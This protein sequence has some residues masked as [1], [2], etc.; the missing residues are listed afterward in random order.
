MSRKKTNAK[1]SAPK[2]GAKKT[3]KAGPKP[4]SKR[5]HSAI[6]DDENKENQGKEDSNSGID[7]DDPR[8]R[9][10]TDDCDQV[11]ERIE[12]FISRG[13]MTVPEFVKAIGVPRDSYLIFMDRHGPDSGCTTSTYENAWRFFKKRELNGIQ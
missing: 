6:E 4:G 5:T 2:A 1:T 9:Y 13:E 10:V 7:D 11:R 3:N 8:L 12:H